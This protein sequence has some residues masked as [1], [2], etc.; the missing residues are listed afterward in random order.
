MPIL[1]KENFMARIKERVGDDTSD[2]AMSFI[3]D[4]TD[5]FNDLETKT[6]DTSSEWEAKY[7]QAIADKDELDKS[8]REKY[9]AR[10]FDGESSSEEAKEDQKED[11]ID[12][13]KPTTFDELFKEREG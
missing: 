6:V 4:M 2:E 13:G 1:D 12:D 3:E 10:F 8:W 7:N 11:V 5:T 9:K